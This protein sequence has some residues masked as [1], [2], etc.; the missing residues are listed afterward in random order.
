MSTKI[1]VFLIPQKISTNQNMNTLHCICMAK[2]TI[3]NML[4]FFQDLTRLLFFSKLYEYLLAK[5]Y[6][7]LY[8]AHLS[9]EQAVSI[10]LS[11]SF[12]KKKLLHIDIL[13]AGTQYQLELT[14]EL[15][16]MKVFCLFFSLYAMLIGLFKTNFLLTRW[17]R[18]QPSTKPSSGS[19]G[20]D[21]S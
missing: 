6:M 15:L 10:K 20:N 8:I 14:V 1:N 13:T 11:K 16:E 3:C 4:A 9:T 17:T 18:L 5:A 2:I 12:N 7:T 21:V 19:C